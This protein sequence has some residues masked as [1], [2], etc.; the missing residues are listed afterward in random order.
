MSNALG[1]L[2]GTLLSG[3][4]FQAYGLEACL[5]VSSAFVLAAALISIALPRHGDT[6]Q[7]PS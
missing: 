6:T 4:V 3:W 7:Q 1:R 5:W 2:V